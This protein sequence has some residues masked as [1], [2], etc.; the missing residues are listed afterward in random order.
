MKTKTWKRETA[1]ALLIFI[2]V[3]AYEQKTEEVKVLAWPTFLFAGAAFGMSW[4]TK[5]MPPNTNSIEY[6][7][8]S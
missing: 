5:Q 2:G 4:A 3:L 7:N 1:T 8:E 6:T